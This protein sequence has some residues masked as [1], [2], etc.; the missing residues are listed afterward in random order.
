MRTVVYTILTGLLFS[1]AAVCDDWQR[2]KKSMEEGGK[3]A[4]EILSEIGS[5]QKIEERISSP[6]AN[7]DKPFSTFGPDKE[8]QKLIKQK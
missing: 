7:S 5:P 4:Q 2:Y 3:A 8:K 1:S 6:T